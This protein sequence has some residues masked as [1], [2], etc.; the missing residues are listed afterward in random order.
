MIPG[1]STDRA[2]A[3]ETAVEGPRLGVPWDRDR[4]PGARPLPIPSYP[5]T[6]TARRMRSGTCRLAPRSKPHRV[7]LPSEGARCLASVH[8]VDDVT[9]A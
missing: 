7:V 6:V 5:V 8:F 1:R 4:S 9:A 3:V 2:L